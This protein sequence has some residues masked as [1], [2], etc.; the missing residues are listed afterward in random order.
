MLGA[1]PHVTPY[2][3]RKKLTQLDSNHFPDPIAYR[4][5]IGALQYCTLTRS[6]ISYTMNQL[7]QFLH[8]PTTEHL[9][10]TK[11]VLRYLKRTPEHRLHFKRGSLQLHAYCDSDWDSDPLDRM[12]T[13]S[14][15]VFLG[16]NLVSWHAKKQPVVSRSSTEAKYR[17]MAI[18]I[19]KNLMAQN[20]AQ[21]IRNCSTLSSSTLVWQLFFFF[22]K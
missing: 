20:A 14:Y 2:T 11:R 1:K 4:H 9:K 10:A 13:T 3:S 15:C 16:S 22:S 21:R 12:S 7:C 17:A 19:A 5:I 6:D 8:C 18:T